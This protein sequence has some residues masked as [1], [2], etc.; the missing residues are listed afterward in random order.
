VVITRANLDALRQELRLAVLAAVDEVVLNFAAVEVDD[1]IQVAYEDL[2]PDPWTYR[3]PSAAL[4]EYHDCHWFRVN[5]RSGAARALVGRTEREVWSEM[6]DRIIVFGQVGKEGSRTFYPW[7]EFVRTKDGAFAAII[8]D[9]ARPR[10][11]LREG[12]P[13]PS[14]LATRRVERTDPLFHSVV[15]EPSL[16]LVVDEDDM[17]EMV[18]HGYWV[19]ELRG[20]L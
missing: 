15:G 4:E 3:W 13:L 20:R 18:A 9:P 6:R 14:R 11:P 5:G 1:E 17:A 10:A 12:S 7:T 8:P 19:A 2:G 16:R